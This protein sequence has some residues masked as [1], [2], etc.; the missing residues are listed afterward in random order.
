MIIFKNKT[1]K[2]S[3]FLR[4]HY[5]FIYTDDK[6]ITS[7]RLI[8]RKVQLLLWLKFKEIGQKINFIFSNIRELNRVSSIRCL[9]YIYIY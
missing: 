5:S 3:I 7:I 2:L 9:P 4:K 6:R 8:Y 1:S